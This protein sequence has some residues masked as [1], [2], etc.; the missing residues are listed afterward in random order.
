M[1]NTLNI[2]NM[3]LSKL[4]KIEPYI[5]FVDC[6]GNNIEYIESIPDTVISLNCGFNP[7][8]SLDFIKN[9]NLQ[10]LY[11]Q[12][13]R[14]S[15]NEI[16][17]TLQLL[18]CR[19]CRLKKL[20]ELKNL[21]VLNCKGNKLTELTLNKFLTTLDA[22]KNYITKINEFP[23][24]I[25]YVD[26]SYNKLTSIPSLHEYIMYLKLGNNPFDVE[27]LP[28][29]PTCFS[30]L[31]LSRMVF[32]NVPGINEH[33]IV[34]YLNG[35]EVDLFTNISVDDFSNRDKRNVFFPSE[36]IKC[37][38]IIASEEYDIQEYLQKNTNNIIIVSNGVHYCYKRS[39][40][41][42]HLFTFT[43]CYINQILSEN[44][45]EKLFK[46]YMREYITSRD[47]N[48]I[49]N[50]RYSV[51]KLHKTERI[52]DLNNCLEQVYDVS[53]YTLSDYLST[54]S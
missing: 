48:N 5:N 20:P 35:D 31:S 12:G 52:I 41:K 28:S 36:K 27:N 1:Y 50:R 23:K 15:L 9:T 39:E 3:G 53:Y 45:G 54:I 46:L 13:V 10:N 6:S 47:F 2:S 29:I 25:F 16:P 51:Y 32:N 38:D 44:T 30:V 34:K 17:E 11:I 24:S 37:I 43:N 26:L 8:K 42:K 22:S 4:P 21:R 33:T 18:D 49:M 19:F 7:L 14:I 40:L